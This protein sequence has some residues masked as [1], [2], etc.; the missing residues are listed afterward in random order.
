MAKD[1]WIDY[2]SVE[3]TVGEIKSMLSASGI[4]ADYDDMLKK[5]V[6]S[7]G[8]QVKAI[9]DLLSAEKK[10]VKQ[11]H[12]TLETYAINVHLAASKFVDLDKSERKALETSAEKAGFKYE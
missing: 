8:E 9:K 10:L 11:L 4:P 7:E 1:L 5:L 12:K 2:D 3:S 6:D